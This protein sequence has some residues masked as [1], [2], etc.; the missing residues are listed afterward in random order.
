MEMLELAM[1]KNI[2]ERRRGAAEDRK[3]SGAVTSSLL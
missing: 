2:E 3:K 1:D